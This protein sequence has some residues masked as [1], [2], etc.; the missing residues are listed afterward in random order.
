MGK[1]IQ[2]DLENCCTA[3]QQKPAA[4]LDIRFYGNL[5]DVNYHKFLGHQ[6]PYLLPNKKPTIIS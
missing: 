1:Y 4:L 2:K 6:S 5:F 3:F